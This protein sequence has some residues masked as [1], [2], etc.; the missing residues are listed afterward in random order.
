MEDQTMPVVSLLVPICNVERYLRECLDSAA[1]QTLRDIEVICINDGSTDSSLDIINEY[2][3]RDSR[4]RV[5][6]KPNSGYGD[7]MNQGIAAARGT[8]IGILESDDFMFPDALEKLV[9]KAQQ[10]NA[11][12]VK[13][14]FFLYWSTPVQ[15]KELFS[16]IDKSMLGDAYCPIDRPGIFYKK[17]SIW[18]SIYRRDFLNENNIHFLPTPGASY[19]DAGFNFK[20]WACAQ[21]AAFVDDPILCYRQDNEK[22]SVNSPNKV[23]CVCDEYEEMQRFLDDRP[24]LKS[25]LQGVLMRMKV[26]SYRWNDERL[27]DSLRAEFWSRASEELK[28]DWDAGRVDLSL[29]DPRGETDLRLMIESPTAYI[30]KR[31]DFRKPGKLNTFKHYFKIGGIPLVWRVLKYQRTYGHNEHPDDCT[32]AASRSKSSEAGE[33]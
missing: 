28:R 26:D 29:F 30:E 6:D 15:R 12:V 10:T 22:S 25:K 3:A 27:V 24:Q 16:I 14:D 13:G 4:F 8:Y 32:V 18:S 33:R 7:S 2:V 23:F 9:A 19:Q 1:A 11:Q 31:E 17:P 5:I 21:R 20:V